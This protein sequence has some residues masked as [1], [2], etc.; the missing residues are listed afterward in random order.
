MPVE[1]LEAPVRISTTS[2]LYSQISPER[3]NF[4]QDQLKDEFNNKD[5]TLIIKPLESF[6][7]RLAKLRTPYGESRA[8]WEEKTRKVLEEDFDYYSRTRDLELGTDRTKVLQNIVAKMLGEE[9]A[10]TRVVI[11]R[12][13]GSAEAFAYPD[14]TI[15]V[16][17]PLLNELDTLDEVA[18]VLAHE[19][20]HLKYQTSFRVAHTSELNRFGVEWL[21][22][23]ACDQR[24]KNLLEEA[25]FNSL[26]FSSAIEKIAGFESRGMK[27]QTGLARASQS[28]G[29]HFFLD[30][31]TSHIEQTKIEGEYKNLHGQPQRTNL[32]IAPD[33]TRST[34]AEQ[35]KGILEKL[36]PRDFKEVYESL[37]QN[38]GKGEANY[39]KLKVVHEI[40]ISRLVSN[41]YSQAEAT[42]F[43]LSLQDSRASSE[44]SYLINTLEKFQNVIEELEKA[45]NPERWISIYKN[46]FGTVP[47]EPRSATNAILSLLNWDIY[48]VNLNPDRKGVPITEQTLLDALEKI[49]KLESG[50][51]GSYDQ[52]SSNITATLIRYIRLAFVTR[53]F[54]MQEGKG[55]FKETVDADKVKVFLEEVRRRNISFT[56]AE[57]KRVY[58]WKDSRKEV[59]DILQEVFKIN[60][61]E[62]EFN[63]YKYIDTYFEIFR[64]TYPGQEK[65]ESI[66]NFLKT[67][68]EYLD[69]NKL[70]DKTRQ[71]FISYIDQ[72]IERL[73]LTSSVNLYKYLEAS[74]VAGSFIGNPTDPEGIE[75]NNRLMRFN[76]RLIMALNIY[77]QDGEEFYASLEKAFNEL[78]LSPDGLSQAAL[79]NL[80]QP[81]FASQE[82][83]P[84]LS[85]ATYYPAW[86]AS[87][88]FS[89][90]GLHPVQPIRDYDRFTKLP[91]IQTIIEK[92]SELNFQNFAE[93]N[94]GVKDLLTRLHFQQFEKSDEIRRYELFDDKLLNLVLGKAFLENVKKLLE[95]GVNEEEYPQVY[96][97]VDN[98]YPN[99]TKKDEILRQLNKHYLNSPN[100]SIEAKT[101]YLLR[102]FE[103]VGPEGMIIVAD[104][105]Q[106]IETYRR[107]RARIERKF[108]E[109]LDGAGIVTKVAAADVITSNLTKNFKD[110]IETSKS[111]D[112]DQK[113]ISTKMAM[114]WFHYALSYRGGDRVEY[115][116][117]KAKFIL[118]VLTRES[119]RSLADIFSNAKNLSS[120]QRFAMAHKALT[121]IG[122]AL[123][124]DEN[125]EVLADTLI[126]SLKLKKGFIASVLKAACLEG[127]PK[128]ISFPAANLLSSLLFRAFNINSV[129]IRK[130]ADFEIEDRD[131]KKKKIKE[132]I[133]EAD[134]KRV[135]GSDTRGISVFGSQYKDS[136]QSLAAQLAQQSDQLYFEITSHLDRTLGLNIGS[137]GSIENEVSKNELD[138]AIEAVIKGVEATGALGIRSLQLASQFQRFSPA[139]ERRLAES[140]DSNPGLN[141]LLFWENLNKLAGE[142]PDI[143][144]FVKRVTLKNYL[145][146]GSLQTTY[147]ATYTD[148]NGAQKEVIVKMK[149]PN[150]EAFIK[151]A[152]TIS[153]NVL[154]VVSQDKNVSGARQYARIGMLLTD[155]AQN[156]CLDDIND[157][158]FEVDDD[159]FRPII[160]GY[161]QSVSR[162]QFYAPQ[163]I[164]TTSKVKSED[165][166]P[167]TTLNK[168]LENPEVDEQVKKTIVESVARFFIYQFKKGDLHT[169]EEGKQVRLIHSDPHVGNYI[170]D[171]QDPGLKVG[172]IDRSL[173]LKLEEA[174]V[175]VLDKLVTTSNSTDFVWSFVNRV[176]DINKVRGVE[177]I[178]VQGRV[179]GN[180]TKEFTYQISHGGVNKT[181]L[182]KSILG[183]LSKEQM[184]V[185]LNLRLMIRNIGAFQELGRRYGVDFE[186]LYKEAA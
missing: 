173:Y 186:Q 60:L 119:F 73:N 44:D 135:L 56:P 167:G 133:P 97:F 51:W 162:E 156:W 39:D 128:F 151:Q 38:R 40:I 121:D 122:G 9:K 178:K 139:V 143:A 89:L 93:L 63:P 77:N 74:F 12:R 18:A 78:N 180:L 99:G 107:F 130:V 11:M 117:G 179:I 66:F 181:S 41:G 35:M 185:P 48:D 4:G 17:Q 123:T 24:T 101:S 126:S 42:L 103:Q 5:D 125:R 1:L 27:H 46:I 2:D 105:I 131:F 177:R 150:V 182:L 7:N 64:Q 31:R 166:A 160:A 84:M 75:L 184:D 83:S 174:D 115:D 116:S 149:N 81:L 168:V 13:S 170:V 127:D 47:K 137:I 165:L 54:V 183:E 58:D 50:N 88:N 124:N 112:L 16:S 109:Y 20:S 6:G 22:E 61:E 37:S 80:C 25:G 129:D 152:Y 106:D 49:S 176:M 90:W 175:K 157:K 91:S 140:F 108:Q 86:V 68:R 34:N 144:E 59:I 110:L 136:P 53:E 72:K 36:H 134:L 142:N 87:R 10:E 95:V 171:A 71:E 155:L 120:L 14:G 98:Y 3:N 85:Y 96:E 164:F 114:Y 45:E 158:T 92:S 153:H 147:S 57:F 15:F 82:G 159:L 146:G 30:S 26:A 62:E 19:L 141:K 102:F 111:G 154:E 138:P 52:R 161:N 79:I 43:L 29:A 113:D 104:Q 65:A 118:G 55:E 21:H 145:G 33:L 94:Q 23:A 67:F 70:D 76:L 132:I 148:E 100:V 8:E 172:V 32:E 69:K 163:R 28:V 169:N